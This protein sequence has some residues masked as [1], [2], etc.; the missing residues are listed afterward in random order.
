MSI[1]I[2]L[3]AA[4]GAKSTVTIAAP[5]INAP[6]G[7]AGFGQA[8]M[9]APAGYTNMIFQDTFLGT[10]LNLAK[11]NPAMGAEGGL[12]NNEGKL[13]K[14]P[15]GFPYTG[16]NT[17]SSGASES[18]DSELNCKSQIVVNNGCTITAQPNSANLNPGGIHYPY[19][20]GAMTTVAPP[21]SGPGVT[22]NFTLPTSGKWYV[23]IR[24]KMPDMS[25]GIAPGLWFMPGHSG[26]A[27][28]E[29]DFIQGCFAPQ[30]TSNAALY[31]YFP[32]AIDW[33]NGPA[34]GTHVPNVG[35]DSTAAFHIYGVEVNWAAGTATGYVDGKSIYSASQ[36]PTPQAYEIIVNVQCWQAGLSW[37]TGINGSSGSWQIAEIQAYAG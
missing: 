24:C 6:S 5:V 20:A 25:H 34:A 35:F 11:W 9:P 19:L 3:V 21:G 26:G 2:P 8:I 12:W 16:P 7:G 18:Y 1:I 30:M 27:V 15:N 17:N 23:Q 14:D 32:L 33:D 36:L 13:G 10:A 28:N 31:N 22:A 37:A 29:F 4:D